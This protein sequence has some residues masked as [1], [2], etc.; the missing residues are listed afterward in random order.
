MR[1]GRISAGAEYIFETFVTVHANSV[2]R[3]EAAHVITTRSLTWTAGLARFEFTFVHLLTG[4]HT[5]RLLTVRP[6]AT[7][8]FLSLFDDAVA[9][10]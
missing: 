9:A 1:T 2:S 7:V 5:T 3:G 4:V 8:A 6:V 10:Q